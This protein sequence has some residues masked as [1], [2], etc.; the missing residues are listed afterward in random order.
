MAKTDK[1]RKAGK[2]AEEEAAAKKKQKIVEKEVR[3]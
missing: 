3:N 1:A 2:V